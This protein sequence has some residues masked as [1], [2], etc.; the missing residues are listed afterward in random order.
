[1]ATRHD[2][3]DEP[4][5]REWQQRQPN[6]R[7]SLD[8][9]SQLK[10]LL[11]LENVSLPILSVVG[12]KGKGTIAVYASATLTAA[13]LCVGTLTSPSMLSNRERICVAGSSILPQ[14]YN[15]I[16]QRLSALLHLLPPRHPGDGY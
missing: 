6:E 12:S 8:R 9:A 7:R 3:A 15:D 4:F 11:D 1:M 5:F 16:T 14:E 13:G 2:P 10:T